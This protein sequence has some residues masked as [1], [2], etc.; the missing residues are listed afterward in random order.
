[1]FSAM[2]R[3]PDVDRRSADRQSQPTVLIAEDDEEVGAA[4][5]DTLTAAGYRIVCAGDGREALAALEVERPDVML[6]D[7]FMPRMS[8][9]ELLDI[10][11]RSPRWSDIPRIVMTGA[12]DSMIGVRLDAAVLF[13]PVDVDALL[14]IVARYVERGPTKDRDGLSDA[15]L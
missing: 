7:I 8:G 5:A 11:R 3:L 1:M 14:A 10:V 12:N 9:S 2:A 15:D 4:L 6:I 13:K